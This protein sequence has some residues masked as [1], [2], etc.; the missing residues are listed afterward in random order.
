M[1]NIT[2]EQIKICLETVEQ[3]YQQRDNIDIDIVRLIE[4]YTILNK[5]EKEIKK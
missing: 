4:L 5:I 2:E 1:I 3:I